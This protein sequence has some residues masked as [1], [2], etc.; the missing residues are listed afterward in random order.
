[1]IIQVDQTGTLEEFEIQLN[2]VASKDNVKGLLI[3]SCDANRFTPE[4]LDNILNK[5]EI[6]LFGGIFPA[7]LHGREK[8]EKGTIIIG[9]NCRPVVG[10]IEDISDPELDFDAKL[11]ELFAEPDCGKTMF[12]FADGYSRRIS[13]LLETLY[14]YFGLGVSFLGGGAGSINPTVLDMTNMPCLF[15]NKGLIKDSALLAVVDKTSGVEVNHG[16][17][18]ISGPY[19]VTET[20]GN[21]IKSLDWRSS[22]DVYKEIIAEHSEELIT[23]ANFF[24]IAKNFPFGIDRM[25]AEVIVRD[26]F[27][28]EGDS[29][30]VATEIPQESFVA[31]LTGDKQSLV[32]A[33]ARS[34]E[35]AK[36]SFQGKTEEMVF[37]IDCIS[38][39]LFLGDD[40]SEEVN[41]VW[42]VDTPLVGILALGEIANS[43]KNY[44]ELYNK[45]CVV[46]ILG[47]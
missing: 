13:N 42:Q 1:M 27:T 4:R 32:A 41:A 17:H 24:E 44:M 12:V 34:A 19:K 45:T 37:L 46:G 21:V 8:L 31:V 25:G 11:E 7:I 38:R 23:H 30:I 40:F 5:V 39:V 47:E 33:A 9:L 28:V 6:P 18:K 16:F 29:L 35:T 43:G 20:C 10:I 36:K 3:L 26:P 15:T 14:S 22:F 2:E